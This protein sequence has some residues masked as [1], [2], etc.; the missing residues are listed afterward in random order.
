VLFRH[1]GFGV[2]DTGGLKRNQ[3]LLILSGLMAQGNGLLWS[4][5]I[6]AHMGTYGVVGVQEALI[7]GIQL[8]VVLRCFLQ[9]EEE[10]LFIRA[11]APLDHRI[12]IGRTLVNVEML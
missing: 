2:D 6:D 3:P 8:Q 10:L 5:H 11:E 4:Q 12:V 7:P 1:G 9:S